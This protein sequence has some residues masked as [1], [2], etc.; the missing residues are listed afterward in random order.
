MSR[1]WCVHLQYTSDIRQRPK[2]VAEK[3]DVFLILGP[4]PTPP[5]NLTATVHG[6]WSVM[7]VWHSCVDP[8]VP[9]FWYRVQ[10]RMVGGGRWLLYSKPI[11]HSSGTRVHVDDLDAG[12]YQ[13]RVLAYGVLAFSQPSNSVAVT[14]ERGEVVLQSTCLSLC[15]IIYIYIFA[16]ICH[17]VC[18][19]VFVC[20][21]VSMYLHS[22]V[23]VD[24]K[25][26]II[27]YVNQADECNKHFVYLQKTYS[28]FYANAEKQFI[29]TKNPCSVL[30]VVT[31]TSVF[32][33]VA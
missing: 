1:W 11:L 18:M 23:N 20:V 17:F 7:L 15:L 28:A 8:P 4:I 12:T 5:S 31:L 32:R 13:L 6:D 10:H 3:V 24:T 26:Q 21:H 19:C 33:Q 2:A 16:C 30:S 14:I 29:E 27:L 9:V 25:T 22:A